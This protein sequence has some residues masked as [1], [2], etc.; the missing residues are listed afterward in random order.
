MKH[1]GLIAL[2]FLLAL[3]CLFLGLQMGKGQLNQAKFDNTMTKDSDSLSSA[4]ETGAVQLVTELRKEVNE[5]K[6][7]L[8]EKN[9]LIESMSSSLG[10]LEQQ[11]EL[12]YT[13]IEQTSVQASPFHPEPDSITVEQ[14][15]QWVPESFAN[16]VAS[17]QGDMVELFKRHHQA[18]KN[19]QWATERE[20]ALQDTFSLSEHADMVNISSVNCKATT[21]EIRGEELKQNGW[22]L[23]SQELQGSALGNNVST[24][25]S[26]SGTE[27]GGTLIYMLSEVDDA[28]VEEETNP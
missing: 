6:Q 16:V 17:Q 7:Q 24:W 22:M 26:L 25:T 11:V 10:L 15:S 4:V 18:E 12:A 20:Q 13:E 5:L 28:S 2:A 14:A 3:G 23:V 9:A 8:A 1:S 19:Q 21:C 27:D